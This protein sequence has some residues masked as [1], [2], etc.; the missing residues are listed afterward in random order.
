MRERE[1]VC[2]SVC[3]C[4]CVC[5]CV[6]VSVRACERACVRAPPHNAHC[7]LLFSFS[8]FS[9]ALHLKPLQNELPAAW[10]QPDLLH[11]VR[12]CFLSHRIN[13]QQQCKPILI[14]IIVFSCTVAI[15]SSADCSKR[16]KVC[17]CFV[18]PIS[19]KTSIWIPSSI[20]WLG[21]R[22][23]CESR[24]GRPGLHVPDTP[25]GLCGRKAILNS[26]ESLACFTTGQMHWWKWEQRS[27]NFPWAY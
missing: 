12:C 21:A 6:R 14:F 25:Y 18:T 10:M 1:R 15:S 5:V 22:E 27:P 16:E 19:S 17:P 20:R 4:V 2:E 13:V 24:D 26:T 23:L 9:S 3:V 11:Y 8:F 7:W